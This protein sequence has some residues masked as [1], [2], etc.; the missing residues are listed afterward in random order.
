MKKK[1]LSCAAL[2][3]AL[4]LAGCNS[5]SD[6]VYQ[7]LYFDTYAYFNVQTRWVFPS[8]TTQQTEKDE[9]VW[10]T[11]RDRIKTLEENIS[12]EVETSSVA[13]F[14]KAAAG[15][16]VEVDSD[17]YSILSAA[18]EI[19]T[20]TEGAYNPAVG[21]LVDLWGFS[22]RFNSSDFMP[23]EAYD[24]ESPSIL[25][26]EKYIE[27][28]KKIIDFSQVE[29]S[30]EEGKY[31]ALKPE[32]AQVTIPDAQGNPVTYTMQLN[33]GG[34]G[35]GYAVDLAEKYVRSEGYEYGFLSCG[36]SSMSLLKN[37]SSRDEQ[38][39]WWIKINNPRLG[40]LQ[41]DSYAKVCEQ[42]VCL[43]SSGDYE[44]AYFVEDRRYCHIINPYTGYPV[45]AEPT[46]PDGSGIITASVFGLSATEGDA[47]STALM[48]MGKE[49]AIAYC[50]QYLSDKHVVFVRYDGAADEYTVY[51]NMPEDKLTILNDTLKVE[52]F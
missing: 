42:N 33:L 8:E 31:Y 14:N 38:E 41:G 44:N 37:L 19:Y 48:V 10:L 23:T 35:K 20:R 6:P 22:P 3:G 25:P 43:S 51:T 9:T 49:K 40:V 18:K 29:L 50:E 7:F 5:V 2:S 15:E 26:E 12:T 36:G 30:A 32:S 47:I 45:N 21:I 24:R 11:M 4:L 39:N 27:G 52:R 16:K 17:T 28:F 13:K 46:N 34:I 1:I